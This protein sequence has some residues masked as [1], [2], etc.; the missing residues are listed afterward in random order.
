MTS[1]LLA[2]KFKR[3]LN[4]WK[5]MSYGGGGGNRTRVQR[6]ASISI[7]VRSLHFR[8]SPFSKAYKRASENR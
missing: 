5:K 3:L 6:Y 7:Y 4:L 8:V 2:S 1:A